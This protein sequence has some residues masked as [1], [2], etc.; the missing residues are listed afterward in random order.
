MKGTGGFE[1]FVAALWP[2]TGEPVLPEPEEIDPG[3]VAEASGA[4]ALAEMGAG[5]GQLYPVD[6]DVELL[7]VERHH[8]RDRRHRRQRRLVRPGE[9]GG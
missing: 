4:A 1:S 6:G 5:P 3:H 2:S 8:V 7:V 9:V